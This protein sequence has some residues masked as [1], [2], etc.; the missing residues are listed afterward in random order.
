MR[1]LKFKS[2][3]VNLN[4]VDEQG[5]SLL[6]VV[7]DIVIAD[8]LIKNGAALNTRDKK[9]NTPL[10]SAVNK[11][12]LVLTKRF[13]EEN[14]IQ[15]DWVNKLGNTALHIASQKKFEVSPKKLNDYWLADVKRKR[16]D[17][18]EIIKSLSKKGANPNKINKQGYRPLHLAVICC[19]SPS[20]NKNLIDYLHIRNQVF[21][22]CKNGANPY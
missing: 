22:L 12:N 21:L 9:G 20:I 11:N 14:T 10:H 5:Q 4:T 19:D 18:L 6:H 13:L 8:Y 17:N 16:F 3:G 1:V 7:T 2:A 15:I